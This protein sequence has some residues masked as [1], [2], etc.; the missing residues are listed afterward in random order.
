MIGQRPDYAHQLEA[1]PSSTLAS[2]LGP[3]TFSVDT[4]EGASCASGHSVHANGRH[5]PSHRPIMPCWTDARRTV[6][7]PRPPSPIR[8]PT[9]RVIQFDARA[10]CVAYT[11]RAASERSRF[12]VTSPHADKSGRR[13][14]TTMSAARAGPTSAG[15]EGEGLTV[16]SP[17]RSPWTDPL[18]VFGLR[19]R[20]S[21][22][23]ATRAI[24]ASLARCPTFAVC[25]ERDRPWSAGSVGC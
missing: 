9:S 5:G 1:P 24:I 14:L 6:G 7:S 23:A 12:P 21:T 8:R 22:I 2:G 19:L 20:H 3:S 15:R 10:G 13:T 17:A 16:T 4:R 18:C 25:L 11:S